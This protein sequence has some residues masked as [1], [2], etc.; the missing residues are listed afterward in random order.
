M[1]L[2][3][4]EQNLVNRLNE[5]FPRP[6]DRS[7]EREFQDNTVDRQVD[8]LMRDA[9]NLKKFN[10]NRLTVPSDAEL[11]Y[12]AGL[13]VNEP[14]IPK[15]PLSEGLLKRDRPNPTPPTTPPPSADVPPSGPRTS[16]ASPPPTPRTSGGSG[17]VVNMEAAPPTASPRQTLAG[18]NPA[19]G[20]KPS[21]LPG[22]PGRLAYPAAGAAVDFAFRIAA[23]QPLGQA[24][25]G[26]IGSG[27]GSAAGFA[28]GSALGPMGGFLGGMVG[29][30]LGGMAGSALYNLAFPST[31]EAPRG[32]FDPK[33]GKYPFQGGQTPRVLY[34]AYLEYT[35]TQGVGQPDRVQKREFSCY[36]PIVGV[37]FELL[38]DGNCVYIIR[39]HGTF[40]SGPVSLPM[41]SFIA[42][43]YHLQ[44]ASIEITN[45]IILDGSANLGGNPP[46][47]PIPQDNRTPDSLEHPGNTNYAPPSAIPQ[48]INIT[49]N[50]VTSSPALNNYAPGGFLSKAGGTPRGD[51]PDWIPKGNLG[52][53]EHPD[54]SPL[55]VALLPDAAPSG[56]P[57]SIG[58]PASATQGVPNKSP[59]TF[60]P[61]G[62]LEIV[63]P[64]SPTTT[65]NPTTNPADRSF[66][67]AGFQ[68][69]ILQP[70]PLTANP[71][72]SSSPNPNT[73]P[74]SG[75]PTTTLNNPTPDA[76]RPTPTV[77]P[78]TPTPAP[79]PTTSQPDFDDLRNKL[80]QL[81]LL[82]VGATVLLNP[83][84]NNTTPEALRDAAETGTCRT[85]Q[86]GGCSYNMVNDAVSRG[87]APINEKLNGLGNLANLAANLNELALLKPIKEGVDLANNKLGPLMKG[88]DGISG[89]LGRLSSS[90]GIDRALNLIAI[91]SS[92]H[93]AMMLSASLKITLL[94]VLSS[95]GNATGLLQTSEGDNVDLNAVFNQGIEKFMTLLLGEENYAGLKVGLRKYNAI[96]RAAT[97]SLNA[98]AQ[99]FNSIGEAIETAAEY[100]GKIGNALRAASVVR[101][102]AYNFMSERI[103]VKTSKFMVFQTKVGDVT[104][105]LE[106]INEIAE[107]VVEGQEQYTEAVKATQDF[108]KALADADRPEAIDNKLIKAEAEKIKANLVADPTGEDETGLLSFLTDR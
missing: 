28:A 15:E 85:T 16:P 58:A 19:P 101:E 97:N 103:T 82:I 9:L 48:I 38:S 45:I 20:A 69:T 72:F 47:L 95:V 84:A 1:P 73:A 32:Q 13:P 17:N 79:T 70:N 99:M 76:V 14:I 94:E 10:D 105:V 49:N 50:N 26:A 40:A 96:Y 11:R 52:P 46:S 25:A 60:N 24:A 21:G 71:G 78:P 64:G 65:G 102:N 41:N 42:N 5:Q 56:S 33:V 77:P 3:P 22:V 61:D 81:E 88:A 80:N 31:A 104:Q 6:G 93:N 107:N 89:F 51:S 98:T 106:T 54:F 108:K 12:R 66:P 90:L 100:T 55:P 57:S 37:F 2:T 34:N 36:G 43:S 30:Y 68:P 87:N 53:E 92:L 4:D 75:L 59:F 29:G 23:G 7:Y 8:N 35:M 74:P 67:G 91:A 44:K 18:P 86:P 83:I 27:I 62:S 63:T 39:H